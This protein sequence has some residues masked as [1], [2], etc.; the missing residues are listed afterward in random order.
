MTATAHMAACDAFV[1]ALLAATPLAGGRV[2]GNRRHPMAAEHASQIFVFLDETAATHEV[3]GTT[4]WN[5]RIRVE[6]VARSASGVTAARAADALAQDVHARVMADRSLGGKAIDT[7]ALAMAWTQDE[8]DTQLGVCQL[9]FN[10]WH[11]T[12]DASISA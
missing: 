7:T 2:E 11:A 1:S 6:C 9:L 4:D 3:I 5:T 12:P 8:L 10:V